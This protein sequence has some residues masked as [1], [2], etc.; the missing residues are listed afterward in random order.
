M[1]GGTGRGDIGTIVLVRVS[2]ATEAL[3]LPEQPRASVRLMA[4]PMVIGSGRM[5]TV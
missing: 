4:M 3:G 1:Y 2:G 5:P